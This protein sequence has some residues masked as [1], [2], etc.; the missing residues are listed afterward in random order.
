[1]KRILST[2]IIAI[3][4]AITLNITSAL[5]ADKEPKSMSGAM[6][7]NPQQMQQM[8]QSMLKM[9]DLMHQIQAAKTPEERQKLKQQHLQMMQ[10]HTQMMMPMMMQ[11]M[12]GQGGMM[13]GGTMNGQQMPMD[14]SNAPARK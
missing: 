12:G 1:M 13:G 4:A 3:F 8:Q 14:H 10:A 6:A 7:M 2:S 5:S 9:H 11:G